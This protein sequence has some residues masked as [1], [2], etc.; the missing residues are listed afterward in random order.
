MGM[1]PF[2]SVIVP[3][4]NCRQYISKCI[5]SVLG[6]TYGAWELILIDDG[7]ADGSGEIC[8]SF[9]HDARIKVLHQ[10]NAGA[11]ASRIK[12]IAAAEGEYML[13]LDAD[14]YL[15]KN[16]LEAVKK[17][18][19]VSGC[20]L[21][22]FGFRY[23]GGQRGV[24]RCTLEPRR[25]YSQREI[26]EEVIENTNHSLWNKAVRM[27]KAKQAGY[28]KT[29]KNLSINLDYA[30]IIP[31]VCNIETGYVT[32][33]VLYNYRIYGSSVS[34]SCKVQH[35]FDIGISTEYVMWKLKKEGLFDEAVYEKAN[36]A[37]L[38]MTGFRLLR[39]SG[40]RKISKEDCRKIHKSKVYI[41]SAGAELRKNF[42]RDEFITLKLFRY[43]LY[44]A[45]RLYAKLRRMQGRDMSV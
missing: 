10:D 35:I 23:V 6:Q 14:D 32:D 4:Y 44:W 24:C 3:V 21:V 26:L 20:D 19:D 2:F 30:Q 7:S 43:R 45:L 40:E 18:I 17:A 27:D 37:Y 42:S 11:L 34:H 31:I 25:K 33:D 16:A 8:D 9:L 36:L 28:S 38:K 13:G 1:Q 29:M 15:D 5:E 22:I 39:L 12:G 41:N